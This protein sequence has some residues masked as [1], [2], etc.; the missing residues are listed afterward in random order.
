[1][2]WKTTLGVTCL[3]LAFL[4][5]GVAL[6]QPVSPKADVDPQADIVLRAASETLGKMGAVKFVLSDTIDEVQEDGRKLQFEHARTVS[7]KR[8][9]YFMV[10]VKGDGG[11]LSMWKDGQVLTLLD[12][13]EKIYAELDDPGTINQAVDVLQNEYGMGLPAADLLSEDLYETMVGNSLFV[14]YVGE[15]TV[16]GEPCHHLSF[17]GEMID[18]QLWVTREE[19]P[20]PRKLVIDYKDKP[21][22]PQYTLRIDKIEVLPAVEASYFAPQVPEGC[23][24]VPFHPLKMID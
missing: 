2:N 13:D 3:G 19:A 12:R 10:D 23:E 5:S 20:L 4:P 15:S 14:D 11:N 9:T 17:V 22:E 6:T 18:W 1:M 7:M 24:K 8:P 21:G 16:A